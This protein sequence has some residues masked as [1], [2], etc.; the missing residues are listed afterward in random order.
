[1]GPHT[2]G[3][4]LDYLRRFARALPADQASDA[5][6]L[7]RF[8]SSRDQRAF[9]ALV[10]RH[11][12]LVFQVCHRVVGD[13]HDAEDAFQDTYSR[14]LILMGNQDGAGKAELPDT[15][16]IAAFFGRLAYLEADRLRHK[17]ARRQNRE[18]FVET[19]PEGQEMG[20]CVRNQVLSREIREIVP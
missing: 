11:G 13:L 20:K 17:R 8:V 5:A 3:A 7:G 4:L 19:Y 10:E 18:I 9:A 2:T 15:S 12:P 14:L 1:M 16:D 6:L